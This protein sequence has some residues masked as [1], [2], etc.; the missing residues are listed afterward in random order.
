M[1]RRN[2][3]DG[4]QEEENREQRQAELERLQQ[5]NARLKSLL[6]SHGISWENGQQENCISESAQLRPFEKPDQ[7]L[8]PAEKVNLFRG[9]LMNS[10][11]IPKSTI[12]NRITNDNVGKAQ[13]KVISDLNGRQ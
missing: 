3:N 7:S 6:T 13:Y 9:I 5:E 1:K 8:D 10:V 2:Y 11:F 12:T 4:A